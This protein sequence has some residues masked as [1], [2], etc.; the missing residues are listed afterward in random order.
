LSAIVA[1][2]ILGGQMSV[3]ERLL[4]CDAEEVAVLDLRQAHLGIGLEH[5]V[6]AA[7]LFFQ[8]RQRLRLVAGRNDG[9]GDLLREQGRR[10]LVDDVAD[11]YAVAKGAKPIGAAG[12]CVRA[13]GRAQL[14]IAGEVRLP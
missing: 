10:R 3:V 6:V 11:S 8:E 7:L 13:C 5:E 14:D 12:T 9:V 1:S 4:E 2:K